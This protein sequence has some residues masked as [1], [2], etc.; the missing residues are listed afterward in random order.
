MR[1]CWKIT[2]IWVHSLVVHSPVVT[3]Y[4]LVES[5][6][7]WVNDSFWEMDLYVEF[8]PKW[9]TLYSYLYRSLRDSGFWLMKYTN[10]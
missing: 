3:Q 2:G 5:I 8:D 9:I 6:H 4:I 1:D 10:Q 7:Q